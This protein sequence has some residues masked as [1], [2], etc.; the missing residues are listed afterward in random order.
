MLG[1]V[2]TISFGLPAGAIGEVVVARLLPQGD[3]CGAAAPP[4]SGI[5]IDDLR[6]E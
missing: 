3:P 2:A 4:V 6:T 1:P 5:I